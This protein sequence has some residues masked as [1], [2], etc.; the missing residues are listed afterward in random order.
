MQLGER[1]VGALEGIVALGLEAGDLEAEALGRGGRLLELADRLV[2]GRLDLEQARLARRATGR[3]VGADQV[4]LPGHRGQVGQ[5]GDE[6][7]GRGQVVDDGDL[8]EQSRQRPDGSRRAPRRRPGRTSPRNAGQRRPGR[9]I[10][11]RAA[12]Q[13]QAGSAEVVALEVGDRL[14][15]GVGTASRRPRRPRCRGRPRRPPRS[16]T[17]TLSSAATEPIS[18][19]TVSVAASRAPA[20]S[21]RLSPSSSASCG[22]H[23]PGPVAIGLLGLLASLGQA[24]V[25]VVEGRDGGFVLRVQAL[26]AGVEPGD[27]GLERGEVLL[28]PVGA[29]ER[30][31]ACRGE[32]ADLVVRSG[33]TAT[34][35]R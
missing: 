23:E 19:D 17:R 29:G 21:L 26:L 28:G 12:A 31:L 25:D 27:L 7:A 33:R 20:P 10:V 3:E 2:D 32:P 34:S 14:D 16:P 1:D 9:A 11:R 6:G 24:L 5:V 22:A 8:E 18:P 13:E 35:A 30:L 15:G 4:A